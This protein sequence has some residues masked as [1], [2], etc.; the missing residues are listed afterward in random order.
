[1]LTLPNLK[2]SFKKK[3]KMS[4][5]KKPSACVM[6]HCLE[7][8]KTAVTKKKEKAPDADSVCRARVGG[9]SSCVACAQI[10]PLGPPHE[11]ASPRP[12]RHCTDTASP[13]ATGSTRCSGKVNRWFDPLTLCH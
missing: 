8:M 10:K 2:N 11:L 5:G 1:M 12:A 6:I 9:T 4:L 13:A 7:R 3:L